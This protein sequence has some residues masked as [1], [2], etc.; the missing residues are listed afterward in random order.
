M[1]LSPDKNEQP[2][3]HYRIVFRGAVELLSSPDE[4]AATTGFTVGYGDIVESKA[5]LFAR[6]E[7]IDDRLTRYPIQQAR[8]I[9]GDNVSKNKQIVFLRVD[10]ILTSDDSP[11][12]HNSPRKDLSFPTTC[13]SA[14][15][16]DDKKVVQALPTP[17]MEGDEFNMSNLD[18]S[19]VVDDPLETTI[20]DIDDPW[21]P[22]LDTVDEHPSEYTSFLHS[23]LQRN[24]MCTD[25]EATQSQSQLNTSFGYLLI[26]TSSD[27]RKVAEPCSAP[28]KLEGV[29][30]VN[31]IDAQHPIPVQMGPMIDAPCTKEKLF[32]GECFLTECLFQP[33]KDDAVFLKLTNR[34]GWILYDPS[35][36]ST[37]DALSQPSNL[38]L[39]SPWLMCQ[40]QVPDSKRP[41]QRRIKGSKTHGLEGSSSIASG[42]LS[43]GTATTVTTLPTRISP[44]QTSR[45]QM[46]SPAL[47][48][49]SSIG[50]HS[51]YEDKANHFSSFRKELYSGDFASTYPSLSPSNSLSSPRRSKQLKDANPKFYLMRVRAPKGL[52]V[53]DAPHFQV[54]SIV[55]GCGS[56][57]S[58]TDPIT[59]NA[60]MFHHA[61]PSSNNLLQGLP[62]NTH[63]SS[64]PY[65]VANNGQR[66]IPRGAIFEASSLP[67]QNSLSS[68][69]LTQNSR[70][71]AALVELADGT[72]WAMIPT[73][74]ELR[75]QY[76]QM[77]HHRHSNSHDLSYSAA[78][79]EVG[80]A[81]MSAG[82]VDKG[83]WLRVLPKNG[84][85]VSCAPVPEPATTL[86][87]PSDSSSHGPLREV[88]AR[89]GLSNISRP[90]AAGQQSEATPKASNTGSGRSISYPVIPCGMV[91]QV[92]PWKERDI[93]L[94]DNHSSE[95]RL[96]R[97]LLVI[98]EK[99]LNL[100]CILLI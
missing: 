29:L 78:I 50:C 57:V 85:I 92:A 10:H 62:S 40:V 75:G 4:N 60:T 88:S 81:I 46:G 71:V 94:N 43:I 97:F 66:I 65:L 53:L 96:N 13:S 74:K 64:Q 1:R 84:V 37:L 82:E 73:I 22:P 33:Q 27:K 17:L 87:L 91:I 93:N 3:Q 32:P 28:H 30:K 24:S 83:V 68:S 23:F 86:S 58:S 15:L 99:I 31:R 26:H 8:K 98:C 52:K 61:M 59:A 95:V 69:G 56:S 9:D 14:G 16:I 47:S 36:V 21:S 72:G 7:Q 76:Q 79:E 12:D 77:I 67:Q 2:S 90:N 44:R 11:D 48:G 55:R 51:Q 70:E 54:S 45:G 63:N 6:T 19:A 34:R 100:Y 39:C 80:S 41:R 49:V 20:H 89:S 18:V 5:D 38:N 35:V 42:A 25:D